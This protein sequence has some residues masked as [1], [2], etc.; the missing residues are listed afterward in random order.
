MSP[1]RYYH[2]KK[3]TTT[4]EIQIK[5]CFRTGKTEDRVCHTFR[6]RGVPRK[7]YTEDVSGHHTLHAESVRVFSGLVSVTVLTAIL[8]LTWT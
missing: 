5:G 6:F 1:K 4:T 8:L 2:G 7:R 3:N